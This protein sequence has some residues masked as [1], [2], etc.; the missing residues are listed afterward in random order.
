MDQWKRHAQQ[1]AAA[2]THPTS[3]WR[4]PVATIPRHLL[5]PRWWQQPP[6]TQRWELRDGPADPPGWLQAAYSDRTLVTQVGP[7]HADHAQP[8]QHPTGR[9]TSSSTKPSLTVRLLRHLLVDDNAEVLEVGTGSGYAAALM[10]RRL[11]DHSVT[12]I[13]VDPYLTKTAGQRLDTISLHPHLLT[14][15]ASSPLPGSYDRILSTVAVRPIPPSW[16]AALRPGGR[17]VTTISHMPI[18]ITADKTADGGATG[19]VEWDRAGFMETRSGP[20][21]PAD[22]YQRHPELLDPDGEATTG[23]YPVIDVKEAWELWAMLEVLAPGIHHRYQQ[24]DDGRRTAWMVHPDGSWARATAPDDAQPT[25]HQDGPRRLW[26]LLDQARDHWLSHG[27]LPVYG[28]KLTITP[29]GTI[30]LTRGRWQA[31]IT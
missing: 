31:T 2:I 26:D 7:V 6:D 29:D 5:V 23:R 28:A 18:I 10:A 8:D 11:G 4:Q 3:R 1:L 13:D 9:P 19:Q 27:S 16:L 25:V 15:D 12:S 22:P 24:S 14:A 17:L 21:Y 30:H 20:D